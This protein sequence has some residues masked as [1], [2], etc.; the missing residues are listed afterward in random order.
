MSHFCSASKRSKRALKAG[1]WPLMVVSK[2]WRDMAAR[3]KVAGCLSG[4]RGSTMTS[5]A[6][7]PSTRRVASSAGVL[8]WMSSVRRWPR[9]AISRMRL[10]C[11]DLPPLVTGQGR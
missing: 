11:R 2:G 5:S 7:A 8:D 6:S 9:A 4:R 10:N 3:H 1:A